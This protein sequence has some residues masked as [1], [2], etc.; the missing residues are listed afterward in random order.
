MG[1]LCDECYDCVLWG[2]RRYF[3]E[4][5]ENLFCLRQ[6]IYVSGDKPRFGFPA[7]RIHSRYINHHDTGRLKSQLLYHIL[8]NGSQRTRSQ[9]SAQPR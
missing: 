2:L 8:C 4:D 7:C 3:F 6:E 5:I 1:E 9:K